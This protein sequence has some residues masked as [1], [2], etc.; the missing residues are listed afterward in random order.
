MIRAD[1]IAGLSRRAEELRYVTEHFR[2]LQG[3]YFAWFCGGLLALLLLS[4]SGRISRGH[5]LIVA[6]C[7][8]ALLLA[9]IPCIRAWYR[10]YGVVERHDPET[11]RT[12]PPSIL[13][14]RTAPRRFASGLFWMALGIWAI[15]V[16]MGL[17]RSL[18]AYRGVL[19]LWIALLFTMPRCFYP[20]P[21]NGFIQLR[22]ALYIVGSAIIFFTIFSFPFVPAVRHLG[23]VVPE[24]VCATLLVLSVYDHWLLGHLLSGRTEAVYE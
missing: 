22:R 4:S 8:F 14:E 21:A 3:L 5:L 23:M 15:F 24:I 9:G 13:N 10:R 7:F 6:A 1:A 18:D 16:G 17:F 2:D 20:A 19:N 11:Q 12:W